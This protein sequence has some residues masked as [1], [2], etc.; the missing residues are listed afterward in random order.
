[1]PVWVYKRCNS[2]LQQYWAPDTLPPIPIHCCDH[3][4]VTVSVWMVWWAVTEKMLTIPSHCL[5]WWEVLM[6][7]DRIRQVDNLA[8]PF[9]EPDSPSDSYLVSP[10]EFLNKTRCTVYPIHITH[11][12]CDL[13]QRLKLKNF[14]FLTL[15]DSLDRN[16]SN[17][18]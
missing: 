12:N 5:V 2:R 4:S 8:W 3:V 11:K 14:N 15:V 9:C 6:E 17:I 18:E 7:L 16:I 1:M 10:P 13:P